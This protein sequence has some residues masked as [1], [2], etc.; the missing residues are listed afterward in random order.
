MQ[1]AERAGIVPKGTDT[2]DWRWTVQTFVS[3]TVET[4]V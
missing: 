2:G 3:K 1:S 4:L